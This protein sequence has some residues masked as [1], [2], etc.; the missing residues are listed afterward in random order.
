[1]KK[2][3]NSTEKERNKEK[4]INSTTSL[5]FE[6]GI[7]SITIDE[8]MGSIGLTRGAF[9]SYFKNKSEL[10]D[11]AFQRLLLTS[12]TKVEA[13][14]KNYSTPKD[15]LSRFIDFYL[16]PEHRDNIKTGCPIASLSSDFSRATLKERENYSKALLKLFLS[17]QKIF[18][19]PEKEIKL[20]DWVGITA[21][22]TGA[23]IL[24]RATRDYELSEN[25][26]ANTKNY[27]LENINKD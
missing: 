4:I 19:S 2:R 15:K 10:I 1:M 22:L 8:V 21:T 12:N 13:N 27:I 20:N 16:T 7:S 24:S 26:L 14:I 3:S 9:P 6:K 18:S 23:I 25:I 17:R 5:I 11:L